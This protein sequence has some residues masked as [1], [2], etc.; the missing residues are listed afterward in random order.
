M[1]KMTYVIALHR[2][3]KGPLVFGNEQQIRAVNFLEKLALMKEDGIGQ[4]PRCGGAGFVECEC[5]ECGDV[6]E[7]E[8]EDCDGQGVADLEPPI[9]NYD[10]RQ[11]WLFPELMPPLQNMRIQ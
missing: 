5:D 10:P 4:C 8:C 9:P 7:R 6:H 3:R 1:E 2:V 11:F